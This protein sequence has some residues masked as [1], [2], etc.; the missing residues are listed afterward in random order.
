VEEPQA[1]KLLGEIMIKPT[2]A[3]PFDMFVA[4]LSL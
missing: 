4:Q 2:M 1:A 3:D